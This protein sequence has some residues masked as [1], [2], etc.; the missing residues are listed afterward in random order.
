VRP[1]AAG[2]ATGATGRSTAL[3]RPSSPALLAAAALGGCVLVNVVDPNEPGAI[4]ICPFKLLTGGLDC[5][6]CGVLRATRALTRGNLV[7]A[8]DHNALAVLVLPVLLGMLLT[9]WRA[10]RRGTGRGWSPS[11]GL[12]AGIAVA[13]PVFWLVR[14]LPAAAWLASG[15]A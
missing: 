2:H 1:T 10:A 5:P 15:L 6:G 4:G 13:V 3:G 9:A 8:L 11:P 14:N 7:A 12:A